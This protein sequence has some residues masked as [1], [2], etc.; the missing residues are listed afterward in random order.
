MEPVTKHTSMTRD[1][2]VTTIPAALRDKAAIR[3]DTA[4]TW[5]EIEPQLWLVGP[6]ARHPEDV[7]AVVAA[8][9]VEPSP[10]PKLMRRLIAGEIPQPNAETRTRRGYTL[11]AVPELTEDQMIALGTPASPV[12]RHQRGRE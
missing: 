5:V 2:G 11:V 10:F 9:L 8:A 4:L 6:E 7:A 3:T 12:P 1:R